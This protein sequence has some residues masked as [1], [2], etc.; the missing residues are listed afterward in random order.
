MIQRTYFL[1]YRLIHNALTTMA[2]FGAAMA[3]SYFI[4]WMRL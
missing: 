3:L 1:H 2:G 4:L